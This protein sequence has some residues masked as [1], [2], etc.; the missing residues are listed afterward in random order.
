MYAH[1]SVIIIYNRTVCDY[2]LQTTAVATAVVLYI[3][4]RYN[5]VLA[6]AGASLFICTHTRTHMYI[7]L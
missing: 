5:I 7:N 4:K 3:Y 6:E 1:R 2:R